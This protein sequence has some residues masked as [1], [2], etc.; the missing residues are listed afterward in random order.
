MNDLFIMANL[1]QIKKVSAQLHLTLDNPESVRKQL[2]KINE[3]QQ[4][5]RQ[6]KQEVVAQLNQINKQS[7][8]FGL[9]EA[10]SIGLH[11]FG[12]H[13]LARQ[14]NRQGNRAERRQ[15][16]TNR[17]PYIKMRDLIDKY[18]FEGDRLRTMAQNY[19]HNN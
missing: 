3:A 6:I 8:A 10:A 5:L 7:Q 16:K 11:L 2:Q 17:Q 12:K 13:R 18:L 4:Q 9:D 15:A 14:V 19:L 1:Q